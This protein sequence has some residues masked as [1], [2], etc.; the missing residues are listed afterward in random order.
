[1]IDFAKRLSGDDIK[2]IAESRYKT[3]RTGYGK[4]VCVRKSFKSDEIKVCRAYSQ[5]YS[6]RVFLSLDSNLTQLNLNTI[7]LGG[8]GTGKSRYFVKPNLL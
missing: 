5:I 8:S 2:E 4:Q 3:R 6:Q 7:V 1:M